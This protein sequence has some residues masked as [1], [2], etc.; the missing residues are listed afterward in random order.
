MNVDPELRENI[1]MA[2]Y[3]AGH[4]FYLDLDSLEVFKNDI[5]DFINKSI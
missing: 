4:M 1:Q 3:K 5:D 2:Y